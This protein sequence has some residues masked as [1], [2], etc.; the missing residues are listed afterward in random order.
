M[1]ALGSGGFLRRWIAAL[2]IVPLLAVLVTPKDLTATPRE[3]EELSTWEGQRITELSV[4]GNSKTKDYVILRELETREG[5]ALDLDL[6]NDDLQRLENLGVFSSVNPICRQDSDGVALEV[7]VVELPFLLAFPALAY[8]EQNGFSI[9]AGLESLNLRG[10]NIRFSSKVLVGGTETFSLALTN[11]WFAGNHASLDFRYVYLQRQDDLNGFLETSHEFSPVLGTYIGRNGRA[12]V[13][14]GWFQMGSDTNGKTLDPDNTDDFYRIG[15]S[16][17]L[18]TRDKW[19]NP[20][21]GGWSDIEL[22]YNRQWELGVGFLTGILDQ[23]RF[24]PTHPRN[25][26]MVG[27]LLSVRTGEVGVEVPEYAMY[28]MGGANSIRGYSIDS[29]G[30]VLFG[31]NQLILTLEDQILVKDIREYTIIK[32][33][34]SL[35]LQLAFFLDA[36]IAWSTESQ[37]TM[38]RFKLGGGVGVR[39]LVPGVDM[40]RFDLGIGEGGEVHLHFGIHNKL[41]AQRA[42]I[43]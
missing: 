30:R 10:R 4:S 11:P 12:K 19:R 31:K 9:G 33:P 20:H 40:V 34:A 22:I 23:R 7:Q 43:R 38:D 27:T 32:W 5:E 18:D 8:T 14:I 3:A 6:L 39:L 29:L 36:G 37:F 21:R 28:R 35:G 17:G 41:A 26:L 16:I 2:W 24:V 1:A 25:T 15:G 42:R 13:L